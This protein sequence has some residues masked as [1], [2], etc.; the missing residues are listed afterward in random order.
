MKIYYYY[1]IPK[2]GGL[3]ILAFFKFLSHN[4]PNSKLYDFTHSKNEENPKNIDFNKILST[5]NIRQYD[6]IFIHHHHGYYGL[7][8][9]EN[10]LIEKK[11]ELEINGHTIKIF[12]TIRNVLSF[13]NSRFNYIKDK[14]GY[15]GNKNDYLTNQN[16]WNVQTKYFFF[17]HHGPNPRGEIT[18]DVI[19]KELTENNILRLSNIVD[20]F[21]ETINLS[22]FIDTMSKYFNLNYDY[23]SKKNTNNHSI[24]LNDNAEEILNNN[25]LDCFLLKTYM[26][27]KNHEFNIE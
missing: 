6:Y 4:L 9:Y 24:I 12:T 7:M 18:I 20:I 11:K 21:I 17:C 27:D 13:N 8:H 22:K 25:K 23:K 3:S 2:T 19:N 10:I 14:C 5:E 16:Y 26:N 1:H 15:K